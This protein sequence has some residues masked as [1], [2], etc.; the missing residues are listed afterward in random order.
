MKKNLLISLSVVA[1]LG[2]AGCGSSSSDDNGGEPSPNTAQN[3]SA[4][5]TNPAKAVKIN[6]DSKSTVTDN[7]WHL[8]YQKYVGFKSNGG[9]SGDKGVKVCIAKEYPNLFDSQKKPVE[10]NFKGLTVEN[11]KED[12]DA[13]TKANC[14]DSDYKED[15]IETQIKF[16]DWVDFDGSSMPPVISV[17]TDPSNGWILRSATQTDNKYTYAKIKVKELM[18]LRMNSA[19]LKF[20]FEKFDGTNFLVGVESPVIS[21]SDAA[22]VYWDLETN[23]MVTKNDNWELAVSINPATHKYTIQVN[24]GASGKGSA[25]VG[26]VL[27][28]YTVDTVTNPADTNQVYKYFS[29]KAS[30][31]LAKPGDFGPFQ[32]ST[33]G[34]HKMWP[35][36]TT[37]IFKDGENYYKAQV[38][39]NYGKDGTLPSGNLAIRA[40]K[41]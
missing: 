3:I 8:A 34:D 21:F 2:L 26:M 14:K 6:L 18:D 15:T 39:S 10:A 36:F 33:T 40:Q 1:A 4:D 41:L 37:Y 35:T 17:K 16:E 27:P 5:A 20:E 12:F 23:T 29:D 22:K 13:V 9:T 25:G 32:Y 31:A 28:A 24:G 38:I 7:S 30:G 19:K 11:T